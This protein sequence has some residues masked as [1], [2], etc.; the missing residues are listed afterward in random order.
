LRKDSPTPP[1][2]PIALVS[3]SA[4]AALVPSGRSTKKALFF[5]SVLAIVSGLALAQAA[6]ASTPTGETQASAWR[7]SRAAQSDSLYKLYHP[8]LLFDQ[9]TIPG[10]KAKVLDGG[11]DDDA[12][13]F[14][15]LMIDYVYPGEPETSILS[16]DFGLAAIP[17]LGLGTYLETPEDEAA[18][19]M[20]YDVTTY[21]AEN[22]DVNLNDYDSSL[23]LRSLAL[24]YDLFFTNAPESVRVYVRNEI[25]DYMNLMTTSQAYEAFK[26]RPYLSN[27]STMIASSLGLAAI[28]LSDE[29][30]PAL[31][32]LALGFATEVI[33]AW[34]GFQVDDEGAYNEG[35][36]YAAWSLRHLVYYF[37]ARER[38]DG[39]SYSNTKVMKMEN[40]FAYELLPE[41]NGKT[42]NLNDSSWGDDPLP[43]HHTYFDWAQHEWGSGLSA[44]LYE[45]TAG[46]FGW[47]WGPK[48]DKTATALWN[49]SLTPK[50]PDAVLPG[51][52]VWEDRGL[53]YFR[54]GWPSGAS[55][56]DVMFSFYSGTFQ[57]GH[58]QE[59]QNQFTLTGYG[60]K[61]AVDHGPGN[62]A[63]QSESHNIVFIDGLGQHNAGSSIGTDGNITQYL[64]TDFVDFL[65][66]DA[67]AAY[68]TYSPLKRPAHP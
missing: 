39:F 48:A 55:S 11:Y 61:F 62:P 53:Y 13:S 52:F 7:A 1:P 12:Y 50:Q 8:R 21:I 64:L 32:D 54:T 59:D 34:L 17:M 45:H 56:D 35:V 4:A 57:G 66:G 2:R 37:A 24:G 14:I 10:L 9:G 25:V 15:R 43:Q 42:N 19:A 63:K 23:R 31:V 5:L 18:R 3:F 38:Y 41:G 51:S 49:K 20:G 27:R 22:Y 16:S 30:N 28:C 65:Q 68:T 36:L 40:W 47:D 60:T 6:T 44:Y 46:P 67:T 29:I 33:S 58:A 26:L